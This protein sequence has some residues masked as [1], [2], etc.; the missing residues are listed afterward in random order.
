M[1]LK[2]YIRSF[3]D[4]GTN[5]GIK[6][7]DMIGCNYDGHHTNVGIAG[8]HQMPRL[9]LQTCCYIMLSNQGRFLGIFNNYANCPQQKYSINS[10]LQLAAH[11]AEIDIKPIAMNG[12]QGLHIS[13]YD[14]L[15]KFKIG[16]AYM[17]MMFP[18]DEQID[19][20][21]HVIMT[22]ASVW[23]PRTF[24]DNLFLDE[25]LKRIPTTLID[26]YSQ[27]YDCEGDL[28]THRSQ[29]YT[30]QKQHY[31]VRTR[32]EKQKKHHSSKL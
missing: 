10:V 24:D 5:G 23:D 25:H 9:P 29:Q 13:G 12:D 17:E 32:K 8:D 14:I 3:I 11:G 15:L 19:T 6:G 18:I 31:C 21:P 22:G 1:Q 30:N 26:H 27:L 4:G 20:L 28:I 7:K 2:E 16:L